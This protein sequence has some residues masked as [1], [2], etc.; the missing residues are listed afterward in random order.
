MFR[1]YFRQAFH[2]LMENKLL[3]AISIAGTALAI[4]VVMVIIIPVSYTHLTLP[5]NSRV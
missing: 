5:T 1:Q 2:L 4:S 3:S